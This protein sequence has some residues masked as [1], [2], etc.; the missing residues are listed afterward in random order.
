MAKND[1]DEFEDGFDTFLQWVVY[2]VYVVMAITVIILCFLV[3]MAV[4]GSFANAV[5]QRTI[6]LCNMRCEGESETVIAARADA[7]NTRQKIG[8]N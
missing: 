4:S 6:E 5:G 3:V 7:L 1:D 8:K 2:A